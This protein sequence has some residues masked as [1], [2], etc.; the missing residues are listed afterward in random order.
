MKL[1]T[2]AGTWADHDWSAADNS[3]RGRA[4]VGRGNWEPSDDCDPAVR[5]NRAGSDVASRL[6]IVGVL[7]FC[8]IV[9]FALLLL[10]ICA[11]AGAATKNTANAKLELI[12][13]T[14]APQNDRDP[15][16]GHALKSTNTASDAV[17]VTD[18]DF[19]LMGILYDPVKPVALVNNGVVELNKPV[20]LSTG[21]G[22]VEVTAVA[23]RRDAV[24]LSVS[25][26][27]LE[28]R[29]GGKD[30]DRKEPQQ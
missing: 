10:F 15:F 12:P 26:Q 23:I 18:T 7:A 21:Q 9:V 2:P 30:P 19:R 14:Y 16:G 4:R 3:A 27:K 6:R 8:Q 29:L 1:H 28:L 20:K 22:I 17:N 13:S 24:V 25:G 11:C 5:S